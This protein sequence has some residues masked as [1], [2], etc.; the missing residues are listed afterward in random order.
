MIITITV[1][2]ILAG[3]SITASFRNTGETEN[4][5]SITELE[6][7]KHAI[8]E[9][10]TKAQ[11]TKEAL[12]GTSF[13]TQSDLNTV[14][15]SINSNA[16]DTIVLEDSTVENYKRLY[17]T[18]LKNLGIENAED[19]YIVNYTTGEVINETQ[20]VTSTG[21]TLYIYAKSAD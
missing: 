6:M 7:V 4:S 19:T 13:T 1:L 8:L 21:K 2:V 5:A 14:I 20:K 11:L 3:I 16:T 12:P 15:S 18:D 17:S 9:R 10:Y